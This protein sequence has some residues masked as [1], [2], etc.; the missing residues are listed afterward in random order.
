MEN[1][2]REP[3][4]CSEMI[5]M[6]ARLTA[7]AIIRRTDEKDHESHYF[8]SSIGFWIRDSVLL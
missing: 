8:L 6:D 5:L 4:R 2:E 3:E 1:R 7:D